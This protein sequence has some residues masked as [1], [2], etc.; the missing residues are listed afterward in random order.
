MRSYPD[1][2]VPV[3]RPASVR[4]LHAEAV[5]SHPFEQRRELVALVGAK[6]VAS[7]EVEF[8][9]PC[10]VTETS[11]SSASPGRLITND[12]VKT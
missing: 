4:S 12:A 6:G 3:W 1:P 8:A 10:P 7:S 5:G 9:R 11:R 2:P